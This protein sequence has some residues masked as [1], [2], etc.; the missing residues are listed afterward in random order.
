LRSELAKQ[1]AL[2]W[3]L[4]FFASLARATFYPLIPFLASEMGLSHSQM[5]IITS[6]T[7]M[8]YAA[9]QL[10][11]GYLTDK[12]GFKK[13]MA[14]GAL[15]AAVGL[16]LGF[17]ASSYLTILLAQALVGV[18]SSAS[19]TPATSAIAK[20]FSS[21]RRGFAEGLL[22]SY[23][24]ASIAISM[25][26]GGWM[27][28]ELSWRF[29]YVASAILMLMSAAVFIALSKGMPALAS[30]EV[31]LR[32]IKE[33]LSLNSCLLVVCISME[34]IGFQALLTYV[35][36]YLADV[37]GLALG[38]AV[39]I[40]ALAHVSAV[41][42]R[43]LAGRL[44]D[45]MG[46]KRVIVLSMFIGGVFSYTLLFN[47]SNPFVESALMVGWGLTYTAMYPVA[48][49]LIADVT[50]RELRGTSIGLVTSVALFLG[51]LLQ[52]RLG[53]AI[54]VAGYQLFFP[55]LA[56]IPALGSLLCL[57]VRLERK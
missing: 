53:F 19:L 31:N 25:I 21:K 35:P 37:G 39:T 42:S 41:F 49:T 54:D 3:L 22:L 47:P 27:A 5:G 16:T 20:L 23:V 13:V 8:V 14:G 7:Y 6:V 12:V 34:V 36:K 57:P 10:P 33:V 50:K 9:S 45:V 46:R 48:I 17:T 11:A 1:F 18:G 56:V 2:I 40:T 28:Q 30:P 4:G 38:L 29:V 24:N 43:P 55:L 15:I 52:E 51:G 32:R 26:V 44:S